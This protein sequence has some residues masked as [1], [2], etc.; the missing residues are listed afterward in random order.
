[1]IYL[2]ENDV[3][4]FQGDSITE[5]GRHHNDWDMNHIFGHGYQCLVGSKIAYDSI[6]N[7][8]KIINSAVIGDTVSRM[9]ARW[10]TDTLAHKPTVLS[11][12]IGENDSD[13]CQQTKVGPTPE[14]YNRE[15]RFLLDYTK[16]VLPDV[17]LIIGEPFTFMSPKAIEGDAEEIK[18]C[19]ERIAIC[20]ENAKYAK[21]IAKDYDAVFVPYWDIIKEQFDKSPVGSI[22]WDGIHPTVVTHY[23]MAKQWYKTVDESGILSK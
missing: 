14:M 18:R 7:H 8:P 23:I 15:Y 2:H 5:G 16:E 17:K 10:E 12:L 19:E 20:T 22:V 4:L 11:I 9:L 13:Y 21:Q 6:E 1:M 3:L